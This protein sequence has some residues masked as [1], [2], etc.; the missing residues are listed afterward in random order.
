MSAPP[1]CGP[2]PWRDHSVC[3][4]P[5]D[6]SFCFNSSTIWSNA[7]KREA[8]SRR[9][10]SIQAV[11][12]ASRL[13]PSLQVRTRPTFF[14]VTSPA[15]SK[16]PTCFFMP[17]RVMWNLSA[18]SVI[19]ASLFP[20][21]SR[22]PRR[23]GSESAAKETSRRDVESYKPRRP[24]V[25]RKALS[26]SAVWERRGLSKRDRSLATVSALIAMNRPDQLRSRATSPRSSPNSRTPCSSATDRHGRLRLGPARRR[27]EGGDPRR[28]RGL[29]SCRREALARRDRRHRD[30]PH[31]NRGGPRREERRLDGEGQRRSV[32][33]QIAPCALRLDVGLSAQPAAD[34][35]H[36]LHDTDRCAIH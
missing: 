17:V 18:S 26:A 19:E 23:V 6:V 5:S 36:A 33:R 4:R 28:R 2:C 31:R 27:P 14:V 13:R 21:C 7:S 3:L 10:S 32:R 25:I 22:T 35:G 11:S 16:T 20:S 34:L 9:Y 1:S 24:G 29:D 30:D 15:C 12:S 8:Q